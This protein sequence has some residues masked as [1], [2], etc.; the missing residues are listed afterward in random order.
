MRNPLQALA[1]LALVLVLAAGGTGCV[2]AAAGAGAGIYLTS[3]G[4]SGQVNG[5]VATLA[6]RTRAVFGEMGIAMSGTETDDG[7]DEVE[8]RGTKD[9]MEITVEIERKS[10][11]AAEVAVSAKKSEVEWDKDYARSI[12]SRISGT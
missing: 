4:A 8:I 7:G 11:T 3:R 1:R 5:D 12:L 2:A 10:A 6:A 9:G